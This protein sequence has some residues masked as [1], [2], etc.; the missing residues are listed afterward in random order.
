MIRYDKKLNAEIRKVVANFN[1]KISRLERKHH[2]NLPER[3]KV[4]ELKETYFT[5]SDL[6]YRLKQLEKFSERGVE[7]IITTK[8]GAT[9]TKYE[10][11]IMKQNIRKTK[12]YLTRQINAFSNITPH[13]AGV[14]QARTLAQMGDETLT[15][16][17]AKRKALNK[18]IEKLS[19]SEFTSFRKYANLQYMN[20]TRRNAIFLWDSYM[21]LIDDLAFRAHLD[22]DKVNDF[23]AKLLKM[24]PNKFYMMFKDEQLFST[25]I[26]Y[27]AGKTGVLSDD[28]VKNVQQNFDELYKMI[29]QLMEKYT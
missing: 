25:F 20:M 8:G 3:V 11:A 9:T 21:Q 15:N 19:K 26:D 14:K 16:L 24:N 22:M 2:A 17:K 6:K 29:D 5:R 4:S 18:P 13:V 27:Y 7:E 1:A 10:L 12:A 23:K 28:D